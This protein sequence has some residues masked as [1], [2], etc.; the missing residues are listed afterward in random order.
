VLAGAVLVAAHEEGGLAWWPAVLAVGGVTLLAVGLRPT[1][2]APPS[3]EDE[4]PAAATVTL[5]ELHRE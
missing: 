3:P 2:P 1:T 4:R 5:R